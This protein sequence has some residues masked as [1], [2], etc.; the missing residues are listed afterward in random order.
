MFTV[1]QRAGGAWDVENDLLG[2]R[3]EPEHL[4]AIH[5]QRLLQLRHEPARPPLVDLHLGRERGGR[6]ATVAC[7]QIVHRAHRFLVALRRGRPGLQHL[8]FPEGRGRRARRPLDHG[9]QRSRRPSRS[10]SESCGETR[11]WAWMALFPSEEP[12][13]AVAEIGRQDVE[14]PPGRHVGRT[15]DEPVVS[16]RTLRTFR[17]NQDVRRDH[18]GQ[19][20]AAVL[21]EWVEPPPTA[22][23][24][25]HQGN[26]PRA[27]RS[28]RA[29]GRQGD[30]EVLPRVALGRQ[31]PP[32]GPPVFDGASK[33]EQVG[34][35]VSMVAR[36]KHTPLRRAGRFEQVRK[37]CNVINAPRMTGRRVALQRIVN[38]VHHDRHHA[39]V[40]VR[41]ETQRLLRRRAALRLALAPQEQ[42]WH[43]R[44]GKNLAITLFSRNR[45]GPSAC[46]RRGPEARA[47]LRRT[48]PD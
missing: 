16:Q 41:D 22:A 43:R 2:G 40:R 24:I 48:P 26:T 36:Q 1:P 13:S 3:V 44:P 35:H 45:P 20:R 34:R 28:P 8:G 18:L 25:G 29:T 23:V 32:A 10:G 14:V 17:T 21:P 9:L 47:C 6:R 7:E 4:V 5:V 19:R 27:L 33:L 12:H 37:R 11:A 46:P 38:R 31:G 30:L 15:N 39:L 42:R